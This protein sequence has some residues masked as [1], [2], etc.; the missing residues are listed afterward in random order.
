MERKQFL[1][2]ST[3][4]AV[5]SFLN[6][7]EGCGPTPQP[8][9]TKNW[10]G[11][12]EFSTDK[13]FKPN[14]V[15]DIQKTL[16]EVKHIKAQG[17]THC[18]N[19]IA[20]S[21]ENLMAMKQMNQ[22]V[23]LDKEKGT[24]TVQA[25][26]KYGELAPYL[27]ENGMALHNLASLPHISVAGSVST[28]THGSGVNNGNL[29]SVVE[30]IEFIDASGNVIQLSR[31]KDSGIFPGIIVALGALGIITKVTLKVQPSFEVKQFVYEKLPNEQLFQHFEEIMSAAYS[32][33]LFTDW[34][35]DSVN[36]VWVKARTDAS[37]AFPAPAEFF[38]AKAATKD[39]HPIAA[40]SAENCTPQMGVAGPWHE[41]L[42]HFKMGFTPSSGVELQAEYFIPFENGVEAMKEIAAMG[43]EIGPHLF[44]SEIRAIA[45]DDHW[46]SMA[47]NRKSIAIHF[48]WKQETEAV[49]ALLPKIEKALERFTPRP[50][51]GKLFTIPK[52]TLASRYE[53]M[54]DFK[55]MAKKYDP[56]GKF[57]ND[58]LNTNI[59]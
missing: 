7:L 47:Y 56:D 33:S 14:S 23:S 35:N 11:N 36:E 18:F 6:P 57:I 10:A 37:T 42:P 21:K 40:N 4:F 5:G 39:L 49:M 12:I 43:E 48:T 25:G 3:A 9:R 52:E 17:T 59:F 27:Q 44:I 26:I 20:D 50:H 16:K 53:K 31:E 8:P 2:L 32:V 29:A 51:W 34:Q 55:S 46:L 13:I 24:V 30:G 19:R 54:N 58:F 15:S 28:G 38:G 1:Q 45:A 41:R 22:V